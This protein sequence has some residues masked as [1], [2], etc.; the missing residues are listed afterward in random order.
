MIRK[1]VRQMLTAQI[2]SALTVSLCLLIDNVMISRFLGQT[3]MAAYS[4]AN[5]ILLAIGALGSL[6]AAGVQVACS[7][8]IGMGSQEETNAGYSSALLLGGAISVAFAVLVAL[9]RSPLA[10]A[11]G[12]GADGAL[13]NET[14]DYLLGFGVGA[15]GSMGALVLV[16]FL[17]MAGQSNLLIVA[18]LSMT[19]ADIALDLLN[20]LVFHGGMLGMGLASSIS[21]YLA[22]GV[23]AFYF[24]SQKCVYRFSWKSVS[25]RKIGE[26]FRGGVPA[27]FNMASSVILVF[28]LNRIFQTTG[29]EIAIAAYAVVSGIGNA[30]NCITTGIGGVSLTLSGILFNEEDRIG[31]KELLE[32][33]FLCGVLLGL[34]MGILL[35]LAAPAL[36]SVFIP[37]DGIMKEMAV[38]GLRLFALGLI[39]CCLNNALKNMYQATGRVGLTEIISLLEGAILPAAAAL[40]LGLIFGTDG[41]WLHFAVGEALTLLLIGLYIRVKARA[42]PWKKGAFLLLK[43]DFGVTDDRLLEGRIQSLQDVTAFVRAAEQFCLSMGETPSLSNKIALCIEEMAG[44]TIKHGFSQDQKE[45]HLS[46]RLLSKADSWILRF[47]DDCRPFDPIHYIPGSPEDALG[48]RLVL[49]ITEKSSYTYSMNMNNLTLKLLRSPGSD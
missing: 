40:I 14:R 33:L 3:G 28:I 29:G 42:L 23:T 1:L 7:K 25:L 30:A 18:V 16:P 39:P 11:M 31:L 5:P 2:F 46:V 20:A 48:I 41:V 22:M 32:L 44:N 15:P 26:L 24:C 19:V 43:E 8:S 34:G 47:R 10:T 37:A 38:L 35:L 6:L 36:V 21:Y 9:F 49:A 12:A 4:L 17:Q 27:G 45:H 13:F